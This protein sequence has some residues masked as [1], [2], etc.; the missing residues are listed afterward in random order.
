MIFATDERNAWLAVASLLR[1]LN[2]VQ[3]SDMTNFRTKF[4]SRRR[5]FSFICHV[6]YQKTQKRMCAGHMPLANT[7]FAVDSNV[8][9]FW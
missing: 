5:P 3:G 4:E 1:A 2:T 6:K 7:A 9:F 8:A